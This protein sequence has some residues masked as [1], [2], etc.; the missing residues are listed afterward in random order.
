MDEKTRSEFLNE[1]LF[2]T[3]FSCTKKK[4]KEWID[5]QEKT[6]GDINR[7][8]MICI[9]RAYRDFN[10]TL[11]LSD[12]EK[13][14]E[15]TLPEAVGKII[16]QGSIKLLSSTD[17]KNFDDNHKMTCCE[18]I[19]GSKN[20]GLL[21]E[22]Y[23]TYGQAQKWVNMTLKYMV[24]TGLWET[25]VEPFMHIPVDSYVL[26]ATANGKQ[27]YLLNNINVPDHNSEVRKHPYNSSSKAWSKW[28][29]K[30]Y[31][32]LIEDLR[33]AV[34]GNMTLFEWECTIWPQMMSE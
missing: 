1:M 6:E 25:E 31:I 8:V 11:R 15:R 9:K 32:D 21:Q 17:K 33:K 14:S 28:E 30:E 3:V 16:E 29:Y 10:R 23:P 5:N 26:K 20:S 24:L 2:S 7:A 27:Y 22:G 4:M 13:K 34:P 18:L 19:D 12:E